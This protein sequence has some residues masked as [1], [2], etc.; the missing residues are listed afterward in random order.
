[1]DASLIKPKEK[2]LLDTALGV[3]KECISVLTL[4]KIS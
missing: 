4:R 1:M 2:V 3:K